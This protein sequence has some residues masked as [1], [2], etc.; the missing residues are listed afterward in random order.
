M[1]ALFCQANNLAHTPKIR[2]KDVLEVNARPIELPPT[3]E[4]DVFQDQVKP[5]L[6]Y[7]RKQAKVM[8]SMGR[9]VELSGFPFTCPT[10][11]QVCIGPLISDDWFLE[12]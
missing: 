6:T 9:T 11:Q 3:K 5:R 4:R 8:N 7:D 12:R 10:I 1:L 2:K